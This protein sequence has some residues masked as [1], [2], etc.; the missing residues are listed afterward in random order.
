MEKFRRDFDRQNERDRMG[1][2]LNS[3]LSLVVEL[4]KRDEEVPPDL[5]NKFNAWLNDIGHR[6]EF[7]E[8]MM[9]MLD[10]LRR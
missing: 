7:D 6:M 2:I 9:R 5:K 1:I 10:E 8:E 4:S 3:Y